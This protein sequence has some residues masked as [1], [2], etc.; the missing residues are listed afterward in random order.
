MNRYEIYCRK[1]RKEIKGPLAAIY[2][3]GRP[4]GGRGVVAMRTISRLWAGDSA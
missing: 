1:K 4:W 3:S 2:S